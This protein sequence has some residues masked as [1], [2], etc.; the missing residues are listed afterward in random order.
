[1]IGLRAGKNPDRFLK[2]ILGL[3]KYSLVGWSTC[4]QKPWQIFEI[5]VAAN[6]VFACGFA[7]FQ[8]KI[9]TDFWNHRWDYSSIRYWV[10]QCKG[11]NPGRFLKSSL[12]LLKYSL[13]GWSMC[14]QK[15]WQIFEI[16]VG[17]TTVFASWLV[18]VQAKTL[19]DLWNHRCYKSSIR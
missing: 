15:P 7:N 3:L 16:I 17:T 19:A 14:R 8:A 2:T 10:G 1:M 12:G 13:V 18:N 11:K 4:R 5:I 9:L 6:Q